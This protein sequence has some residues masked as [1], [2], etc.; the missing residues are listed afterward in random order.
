MSDLILRGYINYEVSQ[1]QKFVFEGGF[2]FKYYPSGG[3]FIW[4]KDTYSTQDHIITKNDYINLETSL[5]PYSDL[6]TKSTWDYQK[7]PAKSKKT[8]DKRL[9]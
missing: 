7:H 5:T 9:H 3:K 8:A 4:V 6:I 2:V 1:I